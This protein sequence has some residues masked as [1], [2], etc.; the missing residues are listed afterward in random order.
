MPQT[1]YIRGLFDTIAGEYDLLNHLLSLGADRGWRRKALR[2]IVEPGRPQQI[3]DLACGTGDFSIAIARKMHPE[4]QLTGLDLS[5]GM[6]A[7][8]QRKLE[9]R[10]LDGK[11][12]TICGDACATG[13]PDAA[14]DRVTIAFGI[15]NFPDR[16]AGLRE[17]LRLLRPGGKIV[18]LELSV[19][20]N[21]VIGFLYKLY[22]KHVLP[23]I[24]GAVSG[25]WKAYRYLPASVLAFPGRKQ[26]MQTMHACGFADVRHRAFSLGI[27]RMYVGTKPSEP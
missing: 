6:L 24:G 16:E 21:P 23:L 12:R 11:V 25:D 20:E 19:P 18:I 9:R 22:F 13:L 5:E 3:L 8:M 10:G 27:C 15:R 7:V 26:W 17:A 4:S 1:D 2:E 14:F